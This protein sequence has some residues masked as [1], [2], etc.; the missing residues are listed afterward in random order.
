MLLTDKIYLN[1]KLPVIQDISVRYIT[2]IMEVKNYNEQRI[3][4]NVKVKR[5][6]SCVY[7]LDSIET[8][9]PHHMT[10]KDW[11]AQLAI[12]NHHLLKKYYT[13]EGAEESIEIF[14]SFIIEELKK[15]NF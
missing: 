14:K 4:F 7:I 12:E 5:S 10:A 13:E 15:Y 2:Y 9:I 11:L 8:D 1:I 6:D 3:L